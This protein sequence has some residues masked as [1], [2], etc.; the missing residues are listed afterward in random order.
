MTLGK[1]IF[2]IPYVGAAINFLKEPIRLAA[3]IAA[4]FFISAVPASEKVKR[5]KPKRL[6]TNLWISKRVIVFILLAIFLVVSA[7]AV[8]YV[9]SLPT[10]RTKLVELYRYEH[11]GTF[12]YTA[13]IKPNILYNKTT[14]GPGE[15]IYISLAKTMQIRF[16]YTFNCTRPAA[17]SGKYKVHINLE[18]PNEWVKP[19]TETEE[20]TFS[21]EG[22]TLT[23]QIN[24][25]QVRE[26]ISE[27]E[28]ETNTRA[29]NYN[30]NVTVD[31]HVEG[32]I[33]GD[34]I[35]EN[36]TPTMTI[37]F[38]REKLIIEG[39]NHTQPKIVTQT[40]SET[41][42]ENINLKYM[43][44]AALAASSATTAWAAYYYMG[45]PKTIT[46][47]MR[48][49]KELIVESEPSTE[50]SR[51]T[52]IIVKSIEDLKKISQQTLKP[53]MHETTKKGKVK[54]HTFY[55]LDADIKYELTLEE[56]EAP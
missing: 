36:F 48:K 5:R 12:D 25:T 34:R 50:T 18:L 32:E 33:M 15:T 39:L 41:L 55:I 45:K 31:I 20:T 54:Q 51:R 6:V 27:I 40:E 44:C 9:Y 35:A 23:Q 47:I 2:A 8:F 11:I 3:L 37:T 4:L 53:I 49:Y 26:L 22:F 17:I 14:I 30:L 1:L 43:S 56:P 7:Y 29:S 16:N 28:K 46:D 13:E 42:Q 24:I 19:Y 10:Q 52:T 38:T 21:S